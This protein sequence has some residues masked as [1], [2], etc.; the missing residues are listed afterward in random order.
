MGGRAAFIRGEW[1]KGC[2]TRVVGEVEEGSKEEEDL[3]RRAMN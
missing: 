3:Q 2:W 1:M